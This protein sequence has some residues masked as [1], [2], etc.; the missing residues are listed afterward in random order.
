LI[1]LFL[2]SAP[3]LLAEIEEGVT[4]RDA[5]AVQIA[6]HALKGAMQSMGAAPGASAA[7]RLET[8]GHMGDMSLADDSLATLKEE[9][10]RLQSTLSALTKEVCA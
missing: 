5:R 2:E 6:S 10:G 7:L 8:I 9:F 4:R 1:D 3:R